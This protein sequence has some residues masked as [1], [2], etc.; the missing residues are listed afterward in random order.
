MYTLSTH[1]GIVTKRRRT[2]RLQWA[3]S[4]KRCICFSDE[5]GE[6]DPCADI[7]SF[8]SCG[9][10]LFNLQNKQGLPADCVN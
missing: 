6:D 4:L 2:S 5:E 10:C 3:H 1:P 9:A 8:Q 7:H